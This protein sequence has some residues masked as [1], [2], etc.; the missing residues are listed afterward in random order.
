[1]I[2]DR[3]IEVEVTEEDL[4][5]MREDG[6]AETDLP[7]TGVKRYRPAR[8]ILKDKVAILLD[9]DIVEHFKS[10]TETDESYQININQTLRRL[11]ENEKSAK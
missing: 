10:R 2:S 11:I 5:Q 7:K 9:A 8:H 4:A 6:I 3:I 1:M